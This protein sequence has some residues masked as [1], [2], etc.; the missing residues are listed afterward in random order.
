MDR[1]GAE[2]WWWDR[3]NLWGGDVHYI[4]GSPHD[5]GNDYWVHSMG[6]SANRGRYPVPEFMVSWTSYKTNNPNIMVQRVAYFPD[7]T[8]YRL[9][10]KQKSDGTH[11]R[12]PDSNWV[13]VL[14]DTAGNWAN[15]AWQWITWEHY[16]ACSH[17]SKQSYNDL[18]YN[19]STGEFLVVWND[20]RQSSN[21]ADV[22]G[23]HL[24]I[25][26]ADSSLEWTDPNGVRGAD[27]AV[28]TPIAASQA[29]EGNYQ[30]PCVAYGVGSNAFLVG[31]EY[32][33]DADN[34]GVGVHGMMHAGAPTWVEKIT[35]TE[36]PGKFILVQNYPNPFN[37][38]TTIEFSLPM[39][40]RAV[41][42]VFDALGRQIAVLMDRDLIQGTYR[43]HWT[44]EDASGRQVSSGIYFYRIEAGRFSA[45]AKMVLMR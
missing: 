6:K 27:P 42:R 26:P 25:D 40:E 17:P 23:Q 39:A 5:W 31:Y 11:V 38:V 3:I 35:T 45:K 22:Y 1:P 15:P 14:L 41:V 8:A 19:Q 18:N 44:G 43:V 2:T 7:S 4:D 29:D 32:D 28:N 30:Y 37:P 36:Q 21:A 16:A 13:A 12:G 33:V 20:W 34:F 10:M 9:G 24:A